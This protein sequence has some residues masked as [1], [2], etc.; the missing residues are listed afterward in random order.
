MD[1]WIGKP[2]MLYPDRVAFQGKIVDAIRVKVPKRQIVVQREKYE[3][4]S[5]NGA[6]TDDDL[7]D[8]R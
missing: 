3:L 1:A 4:S 5:G 6:P 2:I 7:E 8:F